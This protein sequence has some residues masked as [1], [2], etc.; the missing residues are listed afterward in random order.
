ML[1]LV[2][3]FR[4]RG[5]QFLPEDCIVKPGRLDQFFCVGEVRCTCV[6][7]IHSSLTSAATTPIATNG[8]ETRVSRSSSSFNSV[9]RYGSSNAEWVLACQFLQI[10]HSCST[11][12]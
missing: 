1:T 6:T 4:Y 11:S 9:Y 7:Q 3:V 5:K 10:L 12:S 2:V 8:T